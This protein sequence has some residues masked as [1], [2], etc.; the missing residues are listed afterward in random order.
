M[1][2]ER[3]EYE[4]QFA[5]EIECKF[6]GNFF[7]EDLNNEIEDNVCCPKCYDKQTLISKL[8]K[9]D[10]L[11][12]IVEQSEN[13][14]GIY[15]APIELNNLKPIRP[16]K[17]GVSAKEFLELLWEETSELSNSNVFEMRVS[18]IEIK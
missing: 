14:I 15:Q 12:M 5:G 10:Y 8:K 2:I 7:D 18:K 6:C 3:D 1:R 4:N 13:Y 16:S 11:L 9:F 17:F